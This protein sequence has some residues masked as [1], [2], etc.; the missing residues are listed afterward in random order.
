MT[1]EAAL[2]HENGQEH[3]HNHTTQTKLANIHR[4]SDHAPEGIILLKEQQWKIE[5][6]S[7]LVKRKTLVRRI[8]LPAKVSSPPGSRAKILPP[9]AGRIFPL[10]DAPIPPL[11]KK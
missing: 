5:V 8:N 4:H 7:S 1:E 9:A 11:E 6:A 3:D 10:T 2:S